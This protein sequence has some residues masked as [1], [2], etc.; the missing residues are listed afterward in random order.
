MSVSSCSSASALPCAVRAG[1]QLELRLAEVGGDVRM[2]Q[3]RAELGRMRRES[4]RAVG[5][6]AQALFLHPAQAALQ[7]RR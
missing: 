3:R 5:L 2:R 4:E 7:A 1:D 6:D